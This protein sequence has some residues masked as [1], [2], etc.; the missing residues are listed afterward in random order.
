MDSWPHPTPGQLRRLVEELDEAGLVLDGSEPWHDL[1]IEEI[2]Y[3]MR[4]AIHERVVPS[5]GAF[6]EPTT[7]PDGWSRATG[8]GLRHGPLGAK[9]AEGARRYADGVASW[10]LRRSDGDDEFVLL[11]RQAGSERDLVVLSEALGAVV[12]QRHPSGK[13][14]VAGRFGVY[15]WAG[16]G[17][18]HEPQV[19]DLVAALVDDC[20]DGREVLENLLE[21]AVHDLGAR[22]IGA[23][24]VLG[25]DLTLE[26]HLELRQPTPPAI[27][28]TDPISLA[29]LR[30]ALAQTDGA[31]L[32]D[33]SGTL[34]E[35]GVRIVPS[36]HA[37]LEVD[38][39]RGM[40]HTSARRYSHDDPTATVVVVSEDGP[41]TV[42]RAGQTAGTMESPQDDVTE[43]A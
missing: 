4:P 38:G 42:F 25:P 30:H 34:R 16:L 33:P 5:Y 40:R 26:K 1:A 22:G 23:T 37:E 35:L 29:P 31:A 28:I 20:G 41:V 32:F 10:L 27:S 17:W 24:L 13:V 43:P 9:G 21:F 2:A 39:F 36:A 6:I 7:D 11:E 18:H 14:R 12:V 8:L 3:A 19:D 15:R